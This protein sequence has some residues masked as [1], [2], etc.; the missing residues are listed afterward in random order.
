MH[1]EDGVQHI[2][3]CADF[4][5]LWVGG[6]LTVDEA[7][8]W[9]YFL[10]KSS[11]RLL[12]GLRREDATHNDIAVFM[13]ICTNRIGVIDAR[14]SDILF[15]AFGNLKGTTMGAGCSTMS[16]SSLRVLIA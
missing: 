11:T 1:I 13:I 10:C 2:T 14:I 8:K 3:M 15:K 5:A 4:M 6:S 12:T 16:S 7:V 9:L